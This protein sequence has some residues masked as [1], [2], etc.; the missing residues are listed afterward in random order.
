MTEEQMQAKCVEWFHN[1]Y[2]KHRGMLHC[3]NNNSHNKIAGNK[4]RSLGV[5]PGVSDLE[6]LLDGGEVVF[7]ELKIEGGKHSDAQIAWKSKIISAG[8]LY[9][10]A[11]SFEE[12]KKIILKYIGDE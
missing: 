4:A 12:F 10:T 3:N 2:I 9:L 11:F 1:N 8:F 7:I 5:Y 6:L